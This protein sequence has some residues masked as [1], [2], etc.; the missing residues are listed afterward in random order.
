MTPYSPTLARSGRFVFLFTALFAGSTAAQAPTKES[1]DKEEWIAL[2]NGRDLDGWT[3]KITGH[4]L[5]DNFA[6]TFRVEDG[7]L[8]VRY[9]QYESFGNKFGHLFYKDPFSYYRLVV[10]YRFVGEQ[11]PDG[12]GDWALRNSGAMLHSPHPRTM[13]RDQD[14]PISIEAQFLGG[15]GNGKGRSTMNL[16]TPGTEVVYEGSIY[17]EHCLSSTSKTFDG[18]Q[19]VRAEMLVL[20]SGQIT[21]FVNGEEV[22]EYALPQFGGGAVSNFDPAAKP[23]GKLI[24]GGYI[25]LQSESHPIDIRKVELLNLAGCMDSNASNYKRYYVKSEP[26]SCVYADGS[27]PDKSSSSQN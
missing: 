10:E 2:F 6:N 22:L 9:D 13:G 1:A 25:S 5:G 8:K 23:D 16:C 15:S 19:W 27:K 18:D 24:E 17:P 12:P 20:G 3:P 4:A 7:L 26:E 11:A 21:H 14:F